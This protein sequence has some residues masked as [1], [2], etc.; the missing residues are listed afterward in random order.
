VS[1]TVVAVA[2]LATAVYEA[3]INRAVQRASLWPYLSEYHSRTAS[4]YTFNVRN[5]GLGPALV[6]SFQ[7][8]VDGRP[9]RPWG[10]VGT[11][12]GADPRVRIG[13]GS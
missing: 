12:A 4:A 7:L 9:P 1:A 6:R 3:R 2:A 8:R 10:D 13:V 5:V 11:A